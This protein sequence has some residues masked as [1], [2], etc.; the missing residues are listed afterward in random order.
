MQPGPLLYQ[1]KSKQVFSTDDPS[2]VVVRFTDEATAFNA[3]KQATIEGKGR[4]NC[5]ISTKLFEKVADAGVRHHLVRPLSDTDWLCHKVEILPIEVVVRSVIAGSFSRRY[6]LTEGDV[7][8]RPIVEFFYKSDP[9][10]DPLV[11]EDAILAMGW[12]ERWELLFMTD[13][14]LLVHE[15]LRRAW[16]DVGVQLVDA[17]YE[18]GRLD[19]RVLLA[20]ELTPDGARLWDATTGEK[21]D[22]DV[23]RRDLGDLGES[24]RELH[25]RLLGG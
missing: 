11:G 7:L 4:L 10:D 15:T 9:L 17:K 13:T 20:D 18:F 5:A 25:R 3:K 8:P 19:G 21:L 6:G 22:K 14:A 24:Y 23:F 16:A 2:L 1:G 12:S